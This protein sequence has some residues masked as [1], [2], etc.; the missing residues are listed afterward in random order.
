MT[1]VTKS[2]IAAVLLA[3]TFAACKRDRGGM[4]AGRIDTTNLQ[5]RIPDSAPIRM[6]PSADDWSAPRVV[7][8]VTTANDGTIQISK[9]ALVKATNPEVKSFAQSMVTE[10]ASLLTDFKHFATKAGLALDTGAARTGD[11]AEDIREDVKELS[12][13]PR[14]KDWDEDYMDDAVE[15]HEKLVTFLQ[16]AKQR[17]TDVDLRASLD[18]ARTKVDAHLSKARELKTKID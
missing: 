10:H 11:L 15:L 9:I 2:A 18:K 14:G 17:V 3:V 5:M 7:G 16:D 8:F 6:A 12:E 1:H 13:K 4:A